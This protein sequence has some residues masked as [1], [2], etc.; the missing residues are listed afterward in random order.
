MRGLTKEQ[1]SVLRG[2]YFRSVNDAQPINSSKGRRLL[3]L[4]SELETEGLL[5]Q[6]KSE[7]GIQ[8]DITARGELALR[9]EDFII[10]NE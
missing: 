5:T 4:Y 7:F 1:I 9:I 6:S 3:S 10:K 2:D 8:F